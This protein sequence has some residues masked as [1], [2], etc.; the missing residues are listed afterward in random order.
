MKQK[1]TYKA[2]LMGIKVEET[3]ESYTSQ[4]CPFCNGRHQ[5]KG[6][7]F[8][9]SVHKTEIH[10][11]VNE[12]QNIARKK[13]TMAVQPLHS[14][15]FKQPIWYKRFLSEEIRQKTK[16]PKDKPKKEPSI[17]SRMA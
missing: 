12:A 7:H 3:E 9:C 6:R 15:L 4:D 8:I 17:A 5:V 13:H 2:A 11:D 14:V 1:L 16:H 10:R